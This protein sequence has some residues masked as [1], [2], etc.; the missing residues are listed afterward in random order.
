MMFNKILVLVDENVKIQD[1]REVAKQVFKNLN[2]ATDIYFSQGPMDVLDHSCSKLGFG[3]K[4]CVDGT[5]KFEEEIDEKFEIR[6]RL[7]S[8][9]KSEI[10]YSFLKNSLTEIHAVND[11]L[12]KNG[13]ACLII[14]VEKNR[15]GHIR[16]LHEKICELEETKSIKMIL[17]VEHTV[18][19]NDLPTALWRFCNNLDPKRDFHLCKR[20]VTGNQKPETSNYSACIGFDGTR[21]TKQFDDFHRDWP[22][23]IV[24]DDETI[25]AIDNKWDQLGIGQFMPSPSL[26]FKRQLYGEDAAVTTND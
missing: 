24:A 8:G 18:D 25:S 21:K 5:R 16:E 14:S 10:D 20:P 4:M 15:K 26:K 6:S 7:L 13:M 22:N 17:Y 11:S 19:P 12:V 2:P 3:G 1:Y 9:A 23:I